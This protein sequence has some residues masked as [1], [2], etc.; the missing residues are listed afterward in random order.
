MD[1]SLLGTSG[2]PGWKSGDPI[3]DRSLCTQQEW[4]FRGDGV[5]PLVSVTLL[6][7]KRCWV[8]STLYI[9]EGPGDGPLAL[10]DPTSEIQLIQP[11]AGPTAFSFFLQHK[12]CK[13]STTDSNRELGRSNSGLF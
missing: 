3:T 8:R 10:P 13:T 1:L 7:E 4:L 9:W 11:P 6:Q 12:L 2:F 5:V